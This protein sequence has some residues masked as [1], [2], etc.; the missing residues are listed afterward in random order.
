MLL[1][2]SDLSE[3]EP[4]RPSAG[5]IRIWLLDEGKRLHGAD[6]FPD[7]ELPVQ[8]L[9]NGR[10]SASAWRAFYNPLTIPGMDD[11]ACSILSRWAR[12]RR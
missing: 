1:I 3:F 9:D 11:R 10:L 4:H 7:S 5:N 12:L 8:G 2:L 6:V